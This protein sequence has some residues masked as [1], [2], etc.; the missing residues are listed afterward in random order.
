ML[1]HELNDD[2]LQHI[3]SELAL[4][5]WHGNKD[6]LSLALTCRSLSR[7]ARPAH[8]QQYFFGNTFTQI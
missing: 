7:L 6:L 5:F 4:D 8:S 3:V 2:V 1:L